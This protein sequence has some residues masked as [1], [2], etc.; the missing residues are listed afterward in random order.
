MLAVE[1][2]RLRLIVHHVV[3][4]TSLGTVTAQSGTIRID[5]SGQAGPHLDV[6]VGAFGEVALSSCAHL[7]SPQDDVLWNRLEGAILGALLADSLALRDHYEYSLDRTLSRGMIDQLRSPGTD[8]WTP[9]WPTGPTVFHPKRSAGELTDYG[10]NTLW[11]L[12]SATYQR[13]VEQGADVAGA[14]F[15]AEQFYRHWVEAMETHDGYVSSA[16]RAVWQGAM[17]ADGGRELGFGDM[18]GPA[19]AAGLLAAFRDTEE[20][21][22]AARAVCGISHDAES[23]N[24]AALLVAVPHCSMRTGVSARELLTSAVNGESST[25][26]PSLQAL[27]SSSTI[28]RTCVMAA[29]RS[30]DAAVSAHGEWVSGS[31]LGERDLRRD[32]EAL[33]SLS[34]QFGSSIVRQQAMPKSSTIGRALPE[35]IYLALRYQNDLRAAFTANA[36]LG[37]DSAA[38]AA[39]VGSWAGA[40]HG[41][42]ALPVDWLGELVAATEAQKLM[43]ALRREACE[44]D[45]E[46]DE[47]Y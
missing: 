21:D 1:P 30:L 44:E 43:A 3:L 10:D 31:S 7:P 32:D 22:S 24:A 28:V 29:L 20:L 41:S 8:N 14:P 36:M 4:F 37:G 13:T 42:S 23:C 9:G 34:L 47:E 5:W 12:R 40:W 15:V 16:A 33:E 19:R 25:R 46:A 39:L 45:Q 6:G 2:V 38:R 35:A 26:C 11:T 18:S 17:R 27:M